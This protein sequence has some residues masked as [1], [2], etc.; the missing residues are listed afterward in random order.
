MA[1][2]ASQLRKTICLGKA[3]P[4]MRRLERSV[5]CAHT[6]FV[7]SNFWFLRTRRHAAVT[8]QP[9]LDPIEAADIPDA[10]YIQSY[11]V[12]TFRRGLPHPLTFPADLVLPP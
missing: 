4:T 12:F 3:D 7:G 8:D 1:F 9:M 11:N 2:A 5:V 6:G 10:I